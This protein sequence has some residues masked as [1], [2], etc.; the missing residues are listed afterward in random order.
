M[1]HEVI[2]GDARLILG[3][4]LDVLPGLSGVDAVVTDP[5][6]GVQLKEKTSRYSTIHKAEP[7]ADDPAIVREV[8]VPAIMMALAKAKRVLVTPGTRNLMDYPRPASIGTVFSPGAGG[9]DSWGFGCN[10]PILY[11]GKCPYTAAG[12]GSRPNSFASNRA[13]PYTADEAST[14]HPCPKPVSW[15]LWLV[16]RA[17]LDGETILD[18]FMGSGTTGVACIRTGRKFIGIE[19]E[20]KYFD[21]ACK[22]IRD[23]YARSALFADVTEDATQGELLTEGVECLV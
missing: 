13:N 15:M 23:E 6:Y 8:V 11:Y 2:I 21:I 16:S 20:P 1:A 3:D 10:N 5:P 7:Y 18:P 4:C 14:Q 12:L 9:S 22:R 19:K 17:S